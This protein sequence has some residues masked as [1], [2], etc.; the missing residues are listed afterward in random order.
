MPLPAN[1]STCT[2]TGKFTNAD[3]TPT[4]GTIVLVPTP[5]VLLD[6]GASPPTSIMGTP[7]AI[8]LDVN[9]AIPVGFI[10]PATDDLDLNPVDWTYKV[11][12]NTDYYKPED[13]YILAPG[14]TTVDL[15]GVIP[16]EGSPGVPADV[17]DGNRGD[18]TVSGSGLLWNIN[19]DAVTATEIAADAV[20]TSEIAALAVGTA[21]LAEGAVTYTKVSSTISTWTPTVTNLTRGTTGMVETAQYYRMGPLVFVSYNL[22][23]GTGMAVSG[24]VQFSLPVTMAGTSFISTWAQFTDTGT[25]T[26]AAEVV[27]ASTTAITIR[28][29]NASATHSTLSTTT[30]ATV[31][32]TWVATDIIAWG[33]AYLAA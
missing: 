16:V 23:F 4:E 28:P 29:P 14:G 21:E 20:G 32:F 26:Y 27:A 10:V 22:V 3:G 7:I 25:L 12:I 8:D 13:F 31:P 11:I 2:I 5:L 19:A 24:S 17:V 6:V 18:I 15:T 1:V 9:G 33:C 30:S